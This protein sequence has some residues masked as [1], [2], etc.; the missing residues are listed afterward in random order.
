[1]GTTHKM[2]EVLQLDDFFLN[3]KSMTKSDLE[4]DCRARQMTFNPSLDPIL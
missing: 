3:K 4:L 1:M 2:A